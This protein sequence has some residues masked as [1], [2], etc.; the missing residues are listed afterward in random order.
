VIIGCFDSISGWLIR[1]PS[2]VFAAL[3]SV[4]VWQLP[5][6]YRLCSQIRGYNIIV[7]D[8]LFGSN[9]QIDRT[10]RQ[11]LPIGH[12][13]EPKKT[14]AESRRPGMSIGCVSPSQFRVGFPNRR[15]NRCAGLKQ[16]IRPYGVPNQYQCLVLN[17]EGIRVRASQRKRTLKITLIWK[18]KISRRASNTRRL[19]PTMRS[20]GAV[21]F[22][23]DAQLPPALARLLRESG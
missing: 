19:K 4:A 1:R 8:S 20:L 16:Q 3:S 11:G 6:R 17:P 13:E 7:A 15:R 2:C 10:R 9:W 23:V 5:D 22:I 21:E 14:S 18:L 12:W